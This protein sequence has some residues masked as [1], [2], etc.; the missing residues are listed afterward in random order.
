MGVILVRHCRRM[1]LE[2]GLTR[3]GG[4]VEGEENIVW[5]VSQWRRPAGRGNALPALGETSVLETGVKKAI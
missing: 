4:H 1:W 5:E 2:V 3:P